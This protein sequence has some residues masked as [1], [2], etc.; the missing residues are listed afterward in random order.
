MKNNTDFELFAVVCV[1]TDSNK[2]SVQFFDT[3]NDAFSFIDAW[4][5]KV[6]DSVTLLPYSCSF[7]SLNR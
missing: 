6:S 7:K 2:R 5:E 4:T 1:S 3:Q